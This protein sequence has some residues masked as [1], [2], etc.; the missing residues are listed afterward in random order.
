MKNNHKRYHASHTLDIGQVEDARE[1]IIKSLDF[2]K[3]YQL[4]IQNLFI[5]TLHVDNEHWRNYPKSGVHRFTFCIV[6]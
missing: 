3:D 2:D 1:V 6:I 4:M 5:I